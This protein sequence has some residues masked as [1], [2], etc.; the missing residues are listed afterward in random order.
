M[1]GSKSRTATHEVYSVFPNIPMRPNS[2][3]DLFKF[4]EK[5][6]KSNSYPLAHYRCQV[7][8]PAVRHFSVA[9]LLLILDCSERP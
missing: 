2:F 7:L 9:F 1:Y 3:K 5:G 4:A 8:V 6:L